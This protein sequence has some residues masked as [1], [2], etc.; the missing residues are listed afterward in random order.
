[1]GT[2]GLLE[3]LCVFLV[4]VLRWRY[5]CACLKSSGGEFVGCNWLVLV[6]IGMHT[7]FSVRFWVWRN[8][9]GG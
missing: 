2:C 4:G 6:R 3:Y 5:A 9:I 8:V 1:M 7:D